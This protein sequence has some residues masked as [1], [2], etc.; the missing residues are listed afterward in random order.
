MIIINNYLYIF[1]LSTIYV[2]KIH[3]ISSISAQI[4]MQMLPMIFVFL[5]IKKLPY[6]NEAFFVYHVD[7]YNRDLYGNPSF[8]TTVLLLVSIAE[9]I[10]IS[11]AFSRGEPN[12]SAIYR[13]YW[14]IGVIVF[15]MGVWL[16]C[17]IKPARWIRDLIAVYC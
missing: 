4:V 11:I 10:G 8:E 6:Y 16:A 17:V 5:A 1:I 15:E 7:P 9:L 3:I 14:F 13:N 2:L 12:R